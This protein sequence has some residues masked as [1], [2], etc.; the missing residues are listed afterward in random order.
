MPSPNTTNDP[1]AIESPMT[2]VEG[3]GYSITF[4]IPGAET[5]SGQTASIWNGSEDVTATKFS[6][7]A[8]TNGKNTITTPALQN[9]LGGE[10]LTVNVSGLVDSR[11]LHFLLELRVLHPWGAV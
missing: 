1:W 4:R 3:E 10:I 8:T 5:I 9:L 2:A 7:G 6:G 11:T